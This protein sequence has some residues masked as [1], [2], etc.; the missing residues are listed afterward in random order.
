LAEA[1]FGETLKLMNRVRGP[2]NPSTL[3]TLADFASMYQRQGKYALA[4][5]YA[6]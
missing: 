2:E 4:E 5:T 1:L 6:A 3:E